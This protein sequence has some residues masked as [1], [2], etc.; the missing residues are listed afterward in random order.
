M[1][2]QSLVEAEEW[3]RRRKATSNSGRVVAVHSRI[4]VT[5]GGSEMTGRQVR[6]LQVDGGQ[7][8]LDVQKVVLT[9]VWVVTTSEPS[10]KLPCGSLSSAS[11][12][13]VRQRQV[14]AVM[15]VTSSPSV[16]TGVYEAAEVGRLA[17]EADVAARAAS[18]PPSRPA[19]RTLTRGVAV[20]VAQGNATLVTPPMRT[21]IMIATHGE[22][23]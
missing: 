11:S 19:A 3:P 2:C 22:A 16:A 9:G 14:I 20:P 15:T 13:V 8:L 10:T 5:S 7:L 21:L 18:A 6:C 12:M 17:D 23:D 4:T 1:I